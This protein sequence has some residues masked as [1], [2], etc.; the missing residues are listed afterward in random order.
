MVPSRDRTFLD[1]PGQIPELR[2]NVA[3]MGL[4]KWSVSYNHFH[5]TQLGFSNALEPEKG[6]LDSYRKDRQEAY[7]AQVKHAWDK[8]VPFVK[9]YKQGDHLPDSMKSNGYYSKVSASW[10]WNFC[11]VCP[12]HVRHGPQILARIWERPSL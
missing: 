11:K 8:M 9:R 1:T 7:E 5:S 12:H 10:W 4:S 2:L 3:F 6:K